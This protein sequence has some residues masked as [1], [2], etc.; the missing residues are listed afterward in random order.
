MS[1]NLRMETLRRLLC[2]IFFENEEYNAQEGK[3]TK[4]VKA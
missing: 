1:E 2:N 4:S 3:T